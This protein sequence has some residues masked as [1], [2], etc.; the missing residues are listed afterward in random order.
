MVFIKDCVKHYLVSEVRTKRSGSET[1]NSSELQSVH[2]VPD[3]KTINT[4]N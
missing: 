1:R 4:N 2:T 3:G